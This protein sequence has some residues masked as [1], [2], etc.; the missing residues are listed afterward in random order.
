MPPASQ[1]FTPELQR[2][3]AAWLDEDLGRGDLTTSALAVAT[4]R[5][6]WIARAEGVFCGGVLVEPL[7]RLLDPDMQVRLLVADGGAIAPD[8]RLLELE[9]TATALVAGERTSQNLAMRLCGIASA[10]PHTQPARPMAVPLTS[11]R[12]VQISQV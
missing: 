2:Q 10:T 4:G 11:R 3:L 12:V 7:F 5:A 1:P 8:Q 6:H 9:G